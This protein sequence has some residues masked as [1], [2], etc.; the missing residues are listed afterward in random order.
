M[1]TEL[2]AVANTLKAGWLELKMAKWFG[3]KIEVV[4]T[5]KMKVTQSLYKG[6]LYF[7]DWKEQP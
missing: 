4:D 6:K 5:N 7:I 2:Y 1:S 3:K